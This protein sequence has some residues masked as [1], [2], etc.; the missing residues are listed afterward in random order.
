MEF[1]RE[2]DVDFKLDPS[3]FNLEL[4]S[5]LDII[6]KYCAAVTGVLNFDFCLDTSRF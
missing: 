5:F 6:W 1:S 3:V 2:M 4:T